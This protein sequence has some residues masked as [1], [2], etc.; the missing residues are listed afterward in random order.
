MGKHI[1]ISTSNPP[2][3]SYD[4]GLV[5]TELPSTIGVVGLNPRD[6]RQNMPVVRRSTKGG[7]FMRCQNKILPGALSSVYLPPNFNTVTVTRSSSMGPR[8][9]PGQGCRLL[10]ESIIKEQD[11]H[12]F[13]KVA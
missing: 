1:L 11:I 6:L 12:D 13:A 5:V 3:G 9:A 10:V 4:L 7:D 2:S 8:D